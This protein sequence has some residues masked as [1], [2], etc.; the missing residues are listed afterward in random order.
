MFRDLH[1]PIKVA[2]VGAWVYIV[3]ATLAV[4]INFVVD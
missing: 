2:V 1:W 3:A 4:I